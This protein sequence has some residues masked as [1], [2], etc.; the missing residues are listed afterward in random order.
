KI[1]FGASPGVGKTYAMLLEARRLRAEGLDVVVGV[2]ETHGRSETAALLDGL[3]VLPRKEVDYRGRKLQ[4]FDLDAALKRRPPVLLVDELAHTNALGSRH[5]K[6]WQD[7]DELL[8]AGIDVLTTVNVQHMES[9]N[10]IVG[11]ITGIRVAETVPDHVFGRANEVVLVDLPPDDLLLRLKEGKVYL[12]DQAERAIQNFFRKGNLIAL[13]ELALRQTADRVDDQMRA[14]RRATT[15]AQVWQTRD[16]LL[17]C[18]GPS[19]VDDKVVRTAARL[20]AKLD[21]AWH[22]VYAETPA[23][24]RLPEA[25]R[26][27]ILKTLRLAQELGAQTATLPA[28]DAVEAVLDYARRNNLGRIVVGR[29]TRARVRWPGRQSFSRRLGARAPDI[30]LIAVAREEERARRAP[31]TETETERAEAIRRQRLWGYAYAVLTCIGITALATPLRHHIDLANIVMLFLLGVVFVANRFG[32]GPAVL[33]AVLSVASF[34]F[35]FVPPRLTFAVSDVQYLLT[36][37]VML[38]VGLVTGHLTAG[39]RYQARVARSREERARSLYEMARSLSSSLV[40]E[41]VVEISDK[42]VESS[43]R[44]KAAILLPDLS[45]KLQPPLM[46]GA[47]PAYDLAVAQWCYD[48]SAPAGAGTDTLPANPQLYLPLRAPMRV[49]GVLVV[50]PSSTRLLMIPEQR[51]LLDTFAA[52]V[53]IALERIHFVSVAQDTLIKMESERL[54]NTLL[55]ALSHDLRTP[56][57]ALVGLA[58]TLYLDLT[59]AE[60]GHADRASVLREQ[61][62]R[63]SRMVNNLLEMARLQSGEV[64][65]RKDWQ[66]MEEIVGG[67]LK[68]LDAGLAGRPLR[69]DLPA[70]LPLVKCDAGLIERVLVNLLENALK[71]TPPGTAIGVG[72]ARGDAV[73]RVEVWDEGPGLP[74]GQE[75]AMF[76]RFTRGE[77]ESVVPGVGLGLAICEA[78]VEAHGGKIWAENRTP[79]GARFIFTLPLDEQPAVEHEAGL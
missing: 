14:F 5:P 25:Q 54:R 46:Y 52:L 4:E 72:A 68:A 2:V 65:P 43:F 36:F 29:S 6:R 12:P 32:R 71:Y 22:A 77:K 13:R 33:A 51:R 38:I 62:L 10:D 53:A 58:E 57:T 15:E 21:S 59:A 44:A 75:R 41:Q 39:L 26:S 64:K 18:V 28:Q 74:A 73:M 60:S 34:D 30:D 76:A 47:T 56:L 42:F 3:E 24:Q 16:T 50:E 9:L 17:A 19:D 23:L 63:T 20:A 67:A 69:L 48:R 31:A 45:G 55:A 79:H 70:D 40:E 61:A 37:A 11:G 49:R 35:F 1:F 7:V 66:S 8:A 78:I 27:A